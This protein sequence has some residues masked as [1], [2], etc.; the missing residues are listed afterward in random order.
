MAEE[1]YVKIGHFK[2]HSGFAAHLA[3]SH[4]DLPCDPK[5]LSAAEASPLA[6]PINVGGFAVGNRWCVQPMEGWDATPGGLPSEYTIRRW[7]HFGQ[8]G[9]KL[10]WGGEA[11]AVQGDG[12]ANPNQLGIIDDDEDRAQSGLALLLNTLRRAHREKF[13]RDDDL[14]IGLQLTHSGRFCRP[15]DKEKLE[16]R[17][18]YHHPL[19]DPRVGISPTDDSVVITD[20]YLKRLIDKYIRA[21]VVAQRVGF[22]FVDIKHCHGYLGHELLSAHTRPGIFGGSLENRAR[23]VRE[24]VAGIKAKCPGLQIGIRLSAFDHPPFKPDP[25]GSGAGRLGIGI[26]ED[27]SKLL[28]WRWGFGCNPDSPLEIDLREPIELIRMLMKLDVHLFNISCASPYY[29]PH[30]QRPAIFPPSDGYQPPE[31]PLIGVARQIDV[32][33]QLKSVSPGATFIGSGYSYLQEYL[34]HVAQATVRAGWTDFVGIGRMVLAY[35][36]LPADTLAGS[37]VQPKRLCR[38]FSDCTSAPRNGII[39]GCYPLDDH[40]K[41]APEHTQLKAKKAELRK[42]LAIVQ[43]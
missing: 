7:E 3:R 29:N 41:N 19:L 31:D 14:L 12:R 39:S 42:A 8:S 11:F 43:Q 26:P 32:V 22:G 34:P 28:P 17:I 20:D 13:G 27:F 18:A 33:K 30:Y 35:W 16:P 9:C 36:D 4:L 15:R 5:V 24:I 2:H 23:F 25:R 21:A 10:I 40:Y 1:R 38:T 6:H 37:P